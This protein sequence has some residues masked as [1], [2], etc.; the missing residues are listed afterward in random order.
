MPSPHHVANVVTAL[1]S[2][3][4]RLDDEGQPP[5]MPL[6][7]F[8]HCVPPAGSWSL[9]NPG[10]VHPSENSSGFRKSRGSLAHQPGTPA[11]PLPACLPS[12]H[13]QLPQKACSHC[14]RGGAALGGEE[15]FGDFHLCSWRLQLGDRMKPGPR[16]CLDSGAFFSVHGHRAW[17][18]VLGQGVRSW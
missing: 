16:S 4:H 3:T 12:H 11:L 17:R 13:A 8:L 15:A 5:A 14:P 9:G 6:Q 7:P 10:I 1:H 2:E 18:E